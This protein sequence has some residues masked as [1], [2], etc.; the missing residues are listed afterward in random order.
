M[1]FPLWKMLIL[2]IL[3]KGNYFLTDIDEMHLK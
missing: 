3:K 1:Y 2:G